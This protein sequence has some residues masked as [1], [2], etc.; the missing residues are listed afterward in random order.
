[1]MGGRGQEAMKIRADF[2]QSTIFILGLMFCG[3]FVIQKPNTKMIILEP[4]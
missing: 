1:M 3:F 2:L 4:L